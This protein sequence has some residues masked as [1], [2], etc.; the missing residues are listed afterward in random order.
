VRRGASLSL[1]EDDEA[2]AAEDEDEDEDDEEGRLLLEDEEEEGS[3]LRLATRR[4]FTSG[5]SRSL[6]L[7]LEDDDEDD[8]DDEPERLLS[9]RSVPGSRFT[10]SRGEVTSFLAAG[11]LSCDDD[12]EEDDDDSALSGV[13]RRRLTS[14]RSLSSAFVALVAPPE[15]ELPESRMSLSLRR[16]RDLSLRSASDES[17]FLDDDD[18]DEESSRE[19]DRLTGSSCCGTTS[20]S[21]SFSSF[22]TGTRAGGVADRAA[23]S[24]ARALRFASSESRGTLGTLE[25][26]LLS[27]SVLTSSRRGADEALLLLAAGEARSVLDRVTRLVSSELIVRGL[28]P[29]LE[30]LLLSRALPLLL[31]SP[32]SLSCRAPSLL[33]SLPPY[34]SIIACQCVRAGC[35]C[36]RA[37]VL[38]EVGWNGAA[39]AESGRVLAASEADAAA[40]ALLLLARA[41]LSEGRGGRIVSLSLPLMGTAVAATVVGVAAGVSVS[42]SLANTRAARRAPRNSSSESSCRSFSGFFLWASSDE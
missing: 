34:A 24:M 23:G 31:I 27:R 20:G 37:Y 2:G 21:L 38:R 35:A 42:L 9:S 15:A 33:G 4:R 18:D 12:D 39:A 25:S 17:R 16:L 3:S 41:S 32:A 6:S 7:D 1:G 11:S 29:L 28:S 36:V 14:F 40:A 8:E 22:F 13:V 10:D 19:V 5:S 26:L 30:M